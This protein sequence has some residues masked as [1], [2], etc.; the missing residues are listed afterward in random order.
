MDVSAWITPEGR[1]EEQAVCGCGWKGPI[2]SE[3]EAGNRDGDD[4]LLAIV[5]CDRPAGS[6]T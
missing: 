5:E 2:R 3:F 4:H 1:R 6:G